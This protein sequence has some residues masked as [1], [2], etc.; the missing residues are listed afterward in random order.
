MFSILLRQSFRIIL[1]GQFEFCSR[2]REQLE[3]TVS[4]LKPVFRF[5][6]L[7]CIN[8]KCNISVFVCQ[9]RRTDAEH[10]I[11]FAILGYRHIFRHHKQRI[12]LRKTRYRYVKCT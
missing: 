12:N 6:E 11:K 2:K 8:K 4:I 1:S 9:I 10:K 3:F 7:L 5:G